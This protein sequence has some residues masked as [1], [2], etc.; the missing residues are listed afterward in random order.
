LTPVTVVGVDADC[1][2]MYISIGVLYSYKVSMAQVD[3]VE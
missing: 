1:P 2:I 3:R